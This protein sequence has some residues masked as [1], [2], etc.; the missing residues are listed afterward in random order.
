MVQGF[1]VTALKNSKFCLYAAF[2]FIY[3]SIVLHFK[4]ANSFYKTFP[5]VNEKGKEG[6]SCS[7]LWTFAQMDRQFQKNSLNAST[8]AFIINIVQ[9]AENT[10]CKCF[11][12]Y[13]IKNTILLVLI[14]VL[15]STPIIWTCCLLWGSFIVSETNEPPN[16][17][18]AGI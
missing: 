7:S 10:A 16:C 17:A 9:K 15:S 3:S 11:S 4:R 12:A 1:D 14:V 2:N 6:Q 18:K 5:F 8:S 13:L